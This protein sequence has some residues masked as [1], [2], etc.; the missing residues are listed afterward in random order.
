MDL[1]TLVNMYWFPSSSYESLDL[2]FRCNLQRF[3]S[4]NKVIDEFILGLLA[5]YIYIAQSK[6]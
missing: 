2:K 3:D 6:I 5:N 4:L 1:G